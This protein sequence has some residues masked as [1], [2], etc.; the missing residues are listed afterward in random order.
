MIN[1]K[2]YMVSVIVN[3]ARVSDAIVTPLLEITCCSCPTVPFFS[4]SAAV[5]TLD[6]MLHGG[7]AQSG[8][9]CNQYTI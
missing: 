8:V 9:S 7:P 4:Y 2:F 5:H 1:K 3:Q 6:D